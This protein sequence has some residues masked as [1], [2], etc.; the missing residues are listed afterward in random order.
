MFQ[1]PVVTDNGNF[2]VDA[3]F[4]KVGCYEFLVEFCSSNSHALG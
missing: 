2:V 3:T 1:G 4:G